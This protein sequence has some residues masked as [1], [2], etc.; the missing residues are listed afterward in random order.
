MLIIIVDDNSTP[1]TSI[2]AI[3]RGGMF[4]STPSMGLS[5][6]DEDKPTIKPYT[7]AKKL[8]Q[9]EGLMTTETNRKVEDD[10]FVM[11]TSGEFKTDQIER[12]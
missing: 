6:S 9:S 11:F 10:H 12:R 1:D 3:Y 2:D 4:S 5:D 8:R 7:L